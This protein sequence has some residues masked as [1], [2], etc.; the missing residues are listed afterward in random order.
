MAP[1]VQLRKDL[2]ASKTCSFQ[3]VIT[4]D[5]PNSIYNF[6]M[7]C[8]FDQNGTLSFTVT[9]P[10][11]I[12]GITGQFSDDSAALTFDDKLLAFPVLAD[13]Q[14]TPV[15]TPWIFVNA[16]RSGYMSA[17]GKEENGFCLYIN[18]SYSDNPIE[19]EIYTD[20]NHIPVRT[21][22]IWEN[23]RILSADIRNFTLQ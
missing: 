6:Q 21:E 13:G 18:D 1:F 9:D 16:L 11:T 7:D 15:S 10:E 4:A 2:L 22:I 17:C 5:Y 14:L 23:R 20:N 19:L 8:A 3:A 12:A